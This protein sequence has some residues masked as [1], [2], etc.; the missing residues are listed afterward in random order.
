[1]VTIERID[2]SV[3]A[4]SG[5]LVALFTELWR[6]CPKHGTRTIE[7]SS[8]QAFTMF[9][10]ESVVILTTRSRVISY[11]LSMVRIIAAKFSPVRDSGKHIVL[12]Q[13]V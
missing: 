2:F 9:R 4:I 13:Y 6:I 3:C 11:S 12:R 7:D 8:S 1:M 10:P 5:C